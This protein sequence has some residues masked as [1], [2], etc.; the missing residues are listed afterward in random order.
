[1]F[2]KDKFEIKCHYNDKIQQIISSI[3]NKY[4]SRDLKV[5]LLPISIFDIRKI[6]TIPEVKIVYYEKD[7]LLK[8]IY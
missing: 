4:W 7:K 5:W 6:S 3:K 1:M 8:L 2:G